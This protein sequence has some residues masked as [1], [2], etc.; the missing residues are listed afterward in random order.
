MKELA[1]KQVNDKLVGGFQKLSTAKMS[2]IKGGT[3]LNHTCLNKGTCDSKNT[4]DCKNERGG[5][6]LAVNVKTCGTF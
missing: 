3:S 1:L 5:C 6:S 2:Q 4:Y